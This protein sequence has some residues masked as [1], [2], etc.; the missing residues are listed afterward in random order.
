MLTKEIIEKLLE[1]ATAVRK[2]AFLI[3][4]NHPIG[5]CLLTDDGETVV[6][7]NVENIISGMGTCAE[8]AT[9]DSAVAMGKY[10]YIAI[11]V[12]DEEE[13]SYPC[14]M[15]LQ[16]LSLFS[17][18]NEIDFDIIVGQTNGKYEAYKLSELLPKQ[19]KNMSDKTIE[20]L[21]SYAVR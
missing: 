18:I 10:K 19:F 12:V 9:V 11:A 3:K 14:G 2:N 15:C 5:A 7:C 4:S 8:R 21:K 6:G 13:G 16:Y 17:M 20:R 1:R